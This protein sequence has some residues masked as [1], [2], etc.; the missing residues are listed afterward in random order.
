MVLVDSL[1]EGI[2]WEQSIVWALLII[3][4]SQ[5]DISIV[6]QG[7]LWLGAW[8]GNSLSLAIGDFSLDIFH[9]PLASAYRF[10]ALHT[11]IV[12]LSQ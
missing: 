7:S 10:E 1:E 5:M 4:T 11:H 2:G 8:V 9:Q 6:L 3:K 12:M